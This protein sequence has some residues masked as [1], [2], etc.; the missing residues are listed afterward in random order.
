MSISKWIK[1]GAAT[2]VAALFTACN[3]NDPNMVSVDE[4]VKIVESKECLVIDVRTAA[5]YEAGHIKDVGTIDFKSAEFEHKF[6]YMDTDQCIALY[7]RSGNRSGQ[8]LKLLKDDLGFTNIV[9]LEG[10]VKAWTA[11]GY[12]LVKD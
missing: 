7:C 11:A 8:A 10:G 1:F 3:T 5:E 9:H 4:F 6:K 2:I 12:E